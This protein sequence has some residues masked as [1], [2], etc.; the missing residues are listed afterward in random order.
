MSL[1]LDRVEGGINDCGLRRPNGPKYLSPFITV[2]RYEIQ[3]LIRVNLKFMIIYTDI[4][5][6]T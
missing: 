1:Q 6:I 2:R 4:I 3:S 5:I